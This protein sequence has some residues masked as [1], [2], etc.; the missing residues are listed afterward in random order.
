ML[1]S[2]VDALSIEVSL[3][4]VGLDAFDRHEQAAGGRHG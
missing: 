4:S 2:N 1:Q 3:G